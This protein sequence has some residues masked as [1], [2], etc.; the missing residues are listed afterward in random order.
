MSGKKEV[1]NI[2]ISSSVK[3]NIEDTATLANELGV[4]I[5]VCKFAD[6]V[7]LDNGFENLLNHFSEALRDFQGKL[8]L[9]GAFFDLNP[10]SKDSRIVDI[11]V[12]RYNQS[13]SIAKKLNARTIVFHTGYNGLV[14]FPVYHEKFIDNQILFWQEFIKRFEDE[15]IT[16]ALENT[17]EDTPEV[18][19]TILEEVNSKYLK[20]CIDTGH[21]N[22]NS[23]C[24]IYRWIDRLGNYL[25]HMH[26]HNNLGD[27]D[28][29]SS[30][31]NGSLDFGKIFETLRKNNLTPNLA[32]EVFNADPAIESIEFL[33][34]QYNL[35]LSKQEA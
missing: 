12:Y 4:N 30:L 1:L 25:H 29:H 8:S 13:L 31:L 24:D 5:E 33:K 14:K 7:I 32:V 15:D 27:Q 9:H 34:S 11:T 23:S 6:P 35:D 3:E 21:V 26:L 22:I 2:F 19:L 16:V 17:Y 10:V 28:A 20:T 18:I